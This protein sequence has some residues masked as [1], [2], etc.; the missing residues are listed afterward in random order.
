MVCLKKNILS[1]KHNNKK[2]ISVISLPIFLAFE[3]IATHKQTQLTLLSATLEKSQFVK[4]NELEQTE[5]HNRMAVR[6]GERDKHR[7]HFY[8]ILFL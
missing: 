8:I 3:A 1:H 4:I 2:K 6:E 7:I 5:N